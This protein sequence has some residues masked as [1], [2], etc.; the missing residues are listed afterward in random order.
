[1]SITA[2]E[3]NS[4]RKMT[5]AGMMDCKHALQEAEGNV[6]AAIEILRKKGQKIAAKRGDNAIGEGVIL[7]KTNA[8]KNCGVLIALNCETD[9]VA[10]NDDFV[11]FADAIADV[12]LA[13]SPSDVEALKAMNLPSAGVSI[14]EEI[15]N[16]MGRL[17]E[18]LE[19]SRYEQV[20]DNC[21]VAYI[22]PGNR[23]S[24][25]VGFNVCVGDEVARDVA[26]QAAAMAPIALNEEALSQADIDKEIEIGRDLAIQ[27]G[28]PA[29]M[30]EKIA[31]G[32]L[33]KWY[34]EVT[35]VNQAF[36]KDNKK[37]VAAYVKEAGGNDC[38]VTSFSR[39]ALS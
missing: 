26:M 37:T 16:Q 9:F 13:E 2:A 31:L 39:V 15:T 21:V 19:L 29:E 17:G 4:L 35:L 20:S 14:G 7:A 6:D 5:G 22:H 27:E 33:K 30:A 10:K 34:K 1:M 11:K 18:R 25:L 23:L 12:A 36:I 38:E 32:R 28:K 8:D 3:V 24:T